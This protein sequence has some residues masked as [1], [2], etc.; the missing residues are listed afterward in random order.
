MCGAELAEMPLW[1]CLERIKGGMGLQD[2]SAEPRNQSA[3]PVRG[4]AVAWSDKG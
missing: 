3:T 2:Q 1:I 4:R